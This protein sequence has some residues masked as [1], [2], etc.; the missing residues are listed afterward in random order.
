MNVELL[1]RQTSDEEEDMKKDET[2]GG[3]S[4]SE[5]AQTTNSTFC[6]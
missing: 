6:R 3:A 2:D 5:S 4:V 1:H